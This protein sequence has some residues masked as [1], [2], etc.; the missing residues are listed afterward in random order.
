MAK[1]KRN[2]AWNSSQQQRLKE[3]VRKYNKE[4]DKAR[5]RKDFA[6]NKNA[7][8][9]KVDYRKLKKEIGNRNEL[10][11]TIK[12]LSRAN[13][14]TLKVIKSNEGAVS[15]KFEIRDL[16][17]KV[18]RINRTRSQ[19][20]ETTGI[21]MDKRSKF[22]FKNMIQSNFNKL[23]KAILNQSKSNYIENSF[24]Q[25]RENYFSALSN[26]GYTQEIID[27][28]KGITEG[29]TNEQFIKLSTSNPFLEVKFVYDIMELEERTISIKQN[30]LNEIENLDD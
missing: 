22:N 2:I 14:D 11:R 29:L 19:I 8:P 6:E 16:K 26:E 25:Y 5:R 28:I 9:K 1:S 17:L 21:E 7:L 3:Q 30:W 15:T 20:E 13:R 10:N 24:N 18:N 12:D 4:I 23:K 27:E